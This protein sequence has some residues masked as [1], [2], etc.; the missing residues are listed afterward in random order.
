MLWVVMVLRAFVSQVFITFFRFSTP[1]GVFAGVHRRRHFPF[2]TGGAFSG[3]IAGSLADR[4]RYRPIFILSHF[5]TAPA[6]LLSLY[7]RDAWVY[8]CSFLSGFFSM[9]TLPLGWC[10]GSSLPQ[11][12][13]HGIEPHDG[14]GPGDRGVMSPIIGKLADLYSIQTVLA[15]LPAVPLLTWCSVCAFLKKPACMNRG[16]HG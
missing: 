11:G 7:L 13:L 12:A 14:F 3:L 8:P 16:S 6:L 2:H 1:G 15:W 10:W 9:A 5:L 4:T